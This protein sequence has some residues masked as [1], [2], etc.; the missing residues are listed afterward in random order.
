MQLLSF[1]RPTCIETIYLVMS[2]SVCEQSCDTNKTSV[3][4]GQDLLHFLIKL[5]KILKF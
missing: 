5:S 3:S 4:G 2:I 1:N